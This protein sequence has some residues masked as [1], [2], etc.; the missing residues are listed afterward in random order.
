MEVMLLEY[1]NAGAQTA[2]VALVLI[3]LQQQRDIKRIKRYLWPGIY[4]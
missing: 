2:H 4:R 3:V 1:L